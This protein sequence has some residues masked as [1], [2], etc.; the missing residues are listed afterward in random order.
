MPRLA[1]IY[2]AAVR[3]MGVYHYN[4]CRLLRIGMS[5]TAVL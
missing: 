3:G 2:G 1:Y 5:A 4:S